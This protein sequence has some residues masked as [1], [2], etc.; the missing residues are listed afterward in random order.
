MPRAA[1][2]VQASAADGYAVRILTP[3]AAVLPCREEAWRLYMKVTDD[4][5]ILAE[6]L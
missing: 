3:V 5:T 4:M 1:R 2:A 6:Y